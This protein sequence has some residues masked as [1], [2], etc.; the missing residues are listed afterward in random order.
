MS[1]L[2]I[3]GMIPTF[4]DEDI[5]QEVIEYLLSQGIELVILDNGSTDMTYKICE[6]YLGS[7]VLKLEQYHTKSFRASLLF[8]MLH[9]IAIE[10]S[11]DWVILNASDEF[12][13]SGKKDLTLKQALTQVDSE[14]YNLIQFDRFDF[15]MT[16]YDEESEK[17]IRDQLRYYS[18][19]GDYVYRAWKYYPG[20]RIGDVAG[21]YPIFPDE[22]RYKIYPKK[23]AMRHYPF[24]TKKQ[25]E[26]KM[27]DR[28][29]G[30]ENMKN[31][32]L[33]ST[34]YTKILEV[35]PIQRA[36]HNNLTKY[37]EDGKWN[38]DLKYRP[39]ENSSD[40][41]KKEDIFTNDGY[42]KTKH[43]TVYELKFLLNQKLSKSI[44]RKF[45]RMLK[46]DKN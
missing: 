44:I 43:P 40:P 11:P 36:N 7:G 6:K 31:N 14:G 18:C 37:E 8:E 38:L 9:H 15:F 1:N 35:D 42:L 41:P 5:I 45:Y 21:H 20:I 32:K 19:Q 22:Y 39:H 33:L 3:I 10:F 13:E 12:L 25:T 27:K 46:L 16:D 24:R 28:L 30:T 23:F 29:R 2:K 26:G 4:N 17:S 34:R